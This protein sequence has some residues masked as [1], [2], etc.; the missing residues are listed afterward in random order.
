VI[1]SAAQATVNRAD[2]A[3]A[4]V[5]V[6]RPRGGI[7]RATWFLSVVLAVIASANASTF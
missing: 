5:S 1:A 6:R 4:G 7:E 3:T 2:A